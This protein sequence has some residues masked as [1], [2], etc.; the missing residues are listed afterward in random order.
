MFNASNSLTMIFATVFAVIFSF[1]YAAPVTSLEEK[2]KIIAKAGE[3]VCSVFK[4]KV[5]QS[6]KDFHKFLEKDE[7]LKDKFIEQSVQAVNDVGKTNPC[8]IVEDSTQ[9]ELCESVDKFVRSHDPVGTLDRMFKAA[10][11]GTK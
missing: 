9:K 8:K 5:E 4:D 1:T 3:K 7:S 2:V 6:C 11:T 10:S